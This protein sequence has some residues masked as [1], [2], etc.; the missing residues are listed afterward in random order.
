MRLGLDSHSSSVV[1]GRPAWAGVVSSVVF[2]LLV[3]A[4]MALAATPLIIAS[5]LLTSLATLILALSLNKGLTLS[6]ANLLALLGHLCA[7]FSFYFFYTRMLNVTY[8]TD[9][10]VGTYMGIVKVLQLQ[11][12]Y[13]YSIKS[14]LD[15]LG[16]PPSF[17]TPRVDGSFEFH[18]NYPALNFLSLIPMYLA[19]LHDL[20]DGVMVF[21]VVSVLAIFS[22]VPSRLKALSLAPF[23]FGFPLAI[24]YSWTD[25]IWAFFVLLTAVFWYRNKGLSLVS[26]GL[27]AATKQ[28]A[29][30]A[31]PFLLIR[32][33][34]EED[35]SKLRG[36]VKGSGLMAAGFLVPNVPFIIASPSSWWAGTIGPYLPSKTPLIPGGIGLSEILP[37]VGFLISPV[38]FS[39]L[40]VI[41]VVSCLVALALSFNRLNRFIWAMPALV[42][43]FYPRS[44]PNYIVYWAFP[45]FF[46]WFK[47]GNPQLSLR[48]L[49]A[50]V[51]K[52][53][54]QPGWSPLGSLRRRVGPAVLLGLVFTTALVGASGAY[55]VQVSRPKV[56]VR[57][58]QMG[59][60]DSLG[61]AT[62]L[63]V[64]ITN[65][66][67][68]SVSPSFFVKWFFL[69]D[70]WRANQSRILRPASRASYVLTAT[71]ALAGIPRGSTFHVAVYDS[72]SG[73][74][75]GQSPSYVS[76]V[77][78]P[79]VAN[80]RFTWWTLD[81]G[82]GRQVPFS[83]KL[84][85]FNL[86]RTE[87][88]IS[89]VDMNSSSGVQLRLNSTTDQQTFGEV[90]LSQRLLFNETD[91]NLL[92]YQPSP[93]VVN[94]R[95]E[96]GARA[97]DGTH[98]LYFVFSAGATEATVTSYAE[99]TTVTVPMEYS[100]W[101]SVSL[102]VRSVWSSQGWSPS[103]SLDVSLFLRS[104]EA[105]LFVAS[106]QQVAH[107]TL[108]P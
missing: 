93:S 59:D 67:P 106:I 16:F 65:S 31:A 1:A 76:S 37:D 68:D 70:L 92:I 72:G 22:L 45:F 74:L 97:T 47:F 78:R 86:D 46:E 63:A 3:A 28:I 95:E 99:N 66:G 85:L 30:V 48:Q 79:P 39:V 71:D 105:G 103:N 21:H 27:A 101:N 13:S 87:G 83:W 82:A 44:L 23:A 98:V 17:Y 32:L 77:A 20:R 55:A 90:A 91:M 107:A 10:I 38:F 75:V 58:D 2:L 15:Q 29:F 4:W 69:W 26:L 19:G 96:L 41:I 6:R 5:V 18:L 35:G 9:S 42:L 12:P 100:G 50:V 57:V 73:Q 62:R 52:F 34:N 25:S 8:V 56:D 60:P 33:W 36:L 7:L 11:N 53:W 51:N 89:M 54:S 88:G 40:T 49:R 14:L 104:Y 81:V 24:G 61:V 84:S 94:G 102:D 64:T 43:F 108:G 80:P